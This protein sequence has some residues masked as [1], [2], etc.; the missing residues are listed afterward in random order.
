M[1]R[2][3]GS[4][5]EDLL[6]KFSSGGAE[7]QPTASSANIDVGLEV[8]DGTVK[9]I[10]QVAKQ[11]WQI[12]KLDLSLNM[13]ADTSQPVLIKASAELPDRQLPGK[14]LADLKMNSLQGGT[15]PVPAI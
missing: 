6:A 15:R 3:D 8:A 1:L 11:T 13:P 10:D 2:S 4:N 5:L 7:K 9:I 12:E 14:L